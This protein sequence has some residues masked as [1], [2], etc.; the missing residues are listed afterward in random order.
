MDRVTTS[1]TNSASR[2]INKPWVR[3]TPNKMKANSP[4]CDNAAASFKAVR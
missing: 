1:M 2:T 3:I 4:P